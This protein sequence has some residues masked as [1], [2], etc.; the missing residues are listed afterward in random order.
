MESYDFNLVFFYFMFQ[1]RCPENRV[2]LKYIEY[3]QFKIYAGILE[4]STP[5]KCNSVLTPAHLRNLSQDS[6]RS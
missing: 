2:S 3:F 6:L 1:S 4:K 5:Y